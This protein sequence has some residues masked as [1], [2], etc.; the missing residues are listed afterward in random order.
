MGLGQ[1]TKSKGTWWS[2][3]N[4]A[5][6]IQTTSKKHLAK[7]CRYVYIYMYRYRVFFS[8]KRL[9][10]MSSPRH[11]TKRH[12]P[13][14]NG[15]PIPP[16]H[17]F[18]QQTRHAN[19][20]LLIGTV[21]HL[22]TQS[23]A[24]K[25][26]QVLESSRRSPLMKTATTTTTTTTTTTEKNIKYSCSSL[27]FRCIGHF[28]LDCSD[29]AI[30]QAENTLKR[31]DSLNQNSSHPIKKKRFR[32]RRKTAL[33][34]KKTN[35][36]IC[37]KHSTPLN[38]WNTSSLEGSR[39]HLK[40]SGMNWSWMALEVTNIPCRSWCWKEIAKSE[41]AASHNLLTGLYT[42][43]VD[44]NIFQ[45]HTECIWDLPWPSSSEISWP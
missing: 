14:W 18:H 21:D 22:V 16:L 9:L 6:T 8:Q 5:Q 15:G 40:S 26:E 20:R 2:H 7:F 32:K 4:F 30:L 43:Q 29:F 33:A 25:F 11:I 41:A 19:G 1:T 23:F 27:N 31:D 17:L 28:L 12:P 39:L 24:G 36:R 44:A 3:L 13:S 37:P 38:G 42:Y 10:K 45:Q 34:T 35:C